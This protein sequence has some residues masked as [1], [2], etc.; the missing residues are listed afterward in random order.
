MVW[1]MVLYCSIPRTLNCCSCSVAPMRTLPN[2]PLSRQVVYSY[3]QTTR[4]S[5]RGWNMSSRKGSTTLE[6]NNYSG[7]PVLATLAGLSK[8]MSGHNINTRTGTH[9]AINIWIPCTRPYYLFGVLSQ[10]KK[11]DRMGSKT[12]SKRIPRDRSIHLDIWWGWNN[13]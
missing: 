13:E 7:R 12:V 9:T 8:I 5:T 10:I 2:R 11:M 3:A 4:H 1:C 6:K